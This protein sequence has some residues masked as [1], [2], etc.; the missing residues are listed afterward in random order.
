MARMLLPSR[1]TVSTYRRYLTLLMLSGAFFGMVFSPPFLSVGLISLVI[2]GLFDPLVGINPAWREG[3]SNSWRSPLFWGMT[4]LY[5][6]LLM[7][8]AQT[9]DWPY[10][11]ERLRIKIPLLALPIIWPGLPVFRRKEWGWFFG[12][13]VIFMVLALTA[14]LVNYGMHFAEIS[15][16]IHKGKPMPVPRNHIRFSILVALAS[17]LSVAAYQLQAFG[18]RH[19]WLALGILLFLGQHVL[20]VRS[21]LAGAYGGLAVLLLIMAWESGHWSPVAIGLLGLVAL[22]VL[23]YFTI[24]SFQTK[25]NYARYELLH[26]D[27]AK[28]TFEYSDEGRLASLRIGLAVWQDNPFFGVGPGN[29]RME[30]D[31]RYA[32]LLPGVEGKR[33]HN[34]FIS[35]LA[36]SGIVGGV[37]TLT[38][39]GLLLVHG[40][41]RRMSVFLSIWTVL[42]LS[43]LVENTLENTVGVSMFCIFLLLMAGSEAR[44][45]RSSNDSIT[46][47]T[48]VK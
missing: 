31:R 14:V 24:P 6:L 34:Q 12:G 29:L 9:E 44:K 15:E 47:K 48:N 23:A 40:L 3:I 36:G 39:F 38:C 26:R 43:C 37:I 4:G 33:P 11:F 30:M 46:Q 32:E 45:D 42:F 8:I 13:F 2:L 16:M 5:L 10:Y 41:R 21:G 28:D 1:Q 35:A 25:F 19:I 17:L 7:G 18:K 27:P 22:P 20:A